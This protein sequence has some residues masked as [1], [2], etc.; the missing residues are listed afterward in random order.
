MFA[1]DDIEELLARLLAY[2]TELMG[3]LGEVG[4]SY[5]MCYVRGP[6]GIIVAPAEQ[7][8]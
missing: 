3:E 8:G 4:D 7:L 1:V 6:E 5:R 2:G